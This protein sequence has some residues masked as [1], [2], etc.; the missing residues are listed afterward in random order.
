MGAI[1]WYQA[2]TDTKIIM[3]EIFNNWLALYSEPW[4]WQFPVTT[5]A[6]S[7]IAFLSFSLPWTLL[8]WL[9]P[10]PLQRFKIQ[11]KPFEVG[12]Y[13]LPTLARIA[14]NS[15]I[16]FL[17]LLAIWPLLRFS[18][19][20]STHLPSWP[21]IVLQLLFFVFLDDFIYYWMHRYM[22][23]NKWLLKHVHSVHHRIRNTCAINGNYFHWAEFVA[24]A[25]IALIPPMLVGAHI[26]VLWAW[27]IFRQL[28][29]SD[30]HCGYDIPWNPAHWL[31]LYEGPVYHDFHHKRFQG[32]YAGFLPYLDR[33]MG[34]TYIKEY[35]QYRA[36]RKT[37]MLP[38]QVNHDVLEKRA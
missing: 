2:T 37:G 19:I 21:V 38:A 1:H 3:T 13:F 17:I 11:Q 9:D 24:T 22:H 29:A 26:Y 34:G 10:K 33:Y 28:E 8:A 4:F 35:L 6:I 32:N 30:G 5:L 7:V 36:A 12:K 31:P 15:S 25:S 16:M 23:E 20:Q 18:T 27:I 14:I